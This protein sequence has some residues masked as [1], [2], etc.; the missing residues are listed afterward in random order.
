MVLVHVT[1]Y[2]YMRA[3]VCVCVCVLIRTHTT[4]VH[5]YTHTEHNCPLIC[6]HITSFSCVLIGRYR[7]RYRRSYKRQHWLGAIS[8]ITLGN[9]QNK[10]AVA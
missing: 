7:G 3:C 1:M 8:D 9:L 4:Y 6:T 2:V 10:T 5:M